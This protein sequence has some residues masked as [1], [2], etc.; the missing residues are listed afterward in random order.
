MD[1][2]FM[3]QMIKSSK[4]LNYPDPGIRWNDVAL[5]RRVTYHP[6]YFAFKLTRALHQWLC[7][8]QAHM[9]NKALEKT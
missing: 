1:A 7:S 3:D 9:N 4:S 5:K 8:I 6:F 2:P